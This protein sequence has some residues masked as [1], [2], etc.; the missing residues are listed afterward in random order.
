M[1][2]VYAPALVVLVLMIAF[3][4]VV[5][6]SH[7][8][9]IMTFVV[10]RPDDIPPEQT[11]GVGY[12]GQMAYAIATKPFQIDE[13]LDHPAYRYQRILYPLMAYALSFGSA[14]L[15][16][17]SLL[18]INL[19]AATGTTLILGYL[20][21]KRGASP[22]WAMVAVLSFNYLIS[23][24]MDLAEPVAY[25]LALAGLLAFERERFA[26]AIM[27]F[28]AAALAKEV[29]LAFPLA[30]G[31]WTLWKKRW[32]L[33]SAILIGTIGPY[34]AWAGVIR[35]WIGQSPFSMPGISPIFL[36]FAGLFK[37]EGFEAKVMV[38]IW[39]MAP[40]ILAGTMALWQL[41]RRP[42][43]AHSADALLLLAN[44]A[45]VAIAPVAT[46]ADP[47]AILRMGIGVVISV[48]I[49]MSAHWPRR[50]A[51][52]GALWL[53]SLLLAVLLPGFLR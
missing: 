25:G 40:A 41:A 3:S 28:A 36:P 46:W 12:D 4:L 1:K 9:D 18:I 10:E 44:V 14:G 31:M 13:A 2:S 43:G 24:R 30:L 22:W 33:A 17:W 8:W 47:V 7:E 20:L 35:L 42:R 19:A 45:M 15:V 16:P 5:L 27:A 50:L 48:L 11:W 21:T 53:P 23:V 39:T 34:F 52:T 26:L 32:L 49:W 51:I 29:V 37:M 38:C 6:A